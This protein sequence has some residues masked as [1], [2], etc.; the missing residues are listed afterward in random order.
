MLRL[1][2]FLDNNSPTTNTILDALLPWDNIN[3]L[4]KTLVEVAMPDKIAEIVHEAYSDENTECKIWS[5]D[6]PCPLPFEGCEPCIVKRI[7]DFISQRESAL[8][9]ENEALKQQGKV[10]V[11][12]LR[13]AMDYGTIDGGHHK[14]WVIDQ[15]VR[16]L[17]HCPLITK[18]ATDCNGKKYTY[19]TL[20]ESKEYLDLISNNDWES[21]IA[22]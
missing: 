6:N 1:P 16:H 12:A 19:I 4:V 13:C 5:K 8:V 21:G 20:G 22:P 15:M 11:E 9:K 3:K 7:Q 14:M 2:I 18:E 17:T 10:M